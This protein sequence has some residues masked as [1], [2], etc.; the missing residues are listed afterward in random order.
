MTHEA[1]FTLYLKSKVAISKIK[2]KLRDFAAESFPIPEYS[3]KQ[4]LAHN[5]AI[6]AISNK[7]YFA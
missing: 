2:V 6:S 7:T 4:D 3:I 1:D 5:N